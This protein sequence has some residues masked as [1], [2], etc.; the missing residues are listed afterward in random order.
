MTF[1][2]KKNAVTFEEK[3]L[4]CERK[5]MKATKSREDEKI[6]DTK[7]LYFKVEMKPLKKTVETF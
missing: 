1:Q 7:W 3:F 6:V 5:K 2:G 4:N